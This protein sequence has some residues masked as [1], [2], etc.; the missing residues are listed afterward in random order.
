MDSFIENLHQA[1]PE[2]NEQEYLKQQEQA[3][4]DNWLN[5]RKRNKNA[6]TSSQTA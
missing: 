2:Y 3:E 6:S 1:G 5:N 4:W